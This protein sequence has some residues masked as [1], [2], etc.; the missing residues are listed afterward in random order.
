MR[1]IIIVIVSVM[2]IFLSFVA[3]AYFA[4]PLDS[5]RIEADITI[6]EGRAAFKLTNESFMH[7][8]T[9]DTVNT[10][11]RSIIIENIRKTPITATVYID[12]PSWLSVSE[13]RI[14]LPPETSREIIF[15]A[16]PDDDTEYDHYLWNITVVYRRW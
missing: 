2:V 12:G 1:T 7:F 5:H 10:A 4:V 16:D 15:T 13:N 8:G 3:V 11:T 9:I 14:R 6:S